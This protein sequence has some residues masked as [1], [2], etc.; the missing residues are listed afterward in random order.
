MGVSPVVTSPEEFSVVT[1]NNDQDNHHKL[2]RRKHTQGDPGNT[3]GAGHQLADIN[4]LHREIYFHRKRQLITHFAIQL[5]PLESG[6]SPKMGSL[7]SQ[8]STSTAIEA[9]MLGVTKSELRLQRGHGAMSSQEEEKEEDSES[10]GMG[11][12]S[13]NPNEAVAAI[14]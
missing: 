1:D 14:G 11:S 9:Q 12:E 10:G 7:E 13:S 5:E 6:G 3:A 2:K 8:S 4:L